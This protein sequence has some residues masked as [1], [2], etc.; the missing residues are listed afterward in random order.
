MPRF[1][2]TAR[3]NILLS[4]GQIVE[5]GRQI[6]VFVNSST[7]QAGNLFDT[8]YGKEAISRAFSIQGIPPT[9]NYMNGAKWDVK[10]ANYLF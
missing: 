9:P 4:G 5:R 1:V 2:L 3:N 10:L 6:E 8:P 7:A